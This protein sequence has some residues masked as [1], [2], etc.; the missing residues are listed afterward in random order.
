MFKRKYLLL[1]LSVLLNKSYCLEPMANLS[2]GVRGDITQ[3]FV[4]DPLSKIKK[5]NNYLKNKK[6]ILIEIY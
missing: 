1:T 5:F 4:N 3:E 2:L 6:N